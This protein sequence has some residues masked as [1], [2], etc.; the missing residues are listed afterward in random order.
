MKKRWKFLIGLLV[1]LFIA[2][3]AA[4][5]YFYNYAV[6]PEEKDF[7]GGGSNSEE[8]VQAEKWM[9]EDPQR[10]EWQIQ[11]EDGLTLSAIYLPA[12]QDQKKTAIIAHGYMGQAENMAQYADL[13]HQLG[14]NVLI[15]DARGHGKS[16]GDYVGFGWDERMDYLHWIDQVL[17]ETHSDERIVLHGESMGA[18]T[19]MMVSGEKMP[20][21]VR[22]IIED[23]G[24]TSAKDEL[25]FQLK[26][27]FGL[28][29][30]PL[31][32]VTSLVT[33]VRAGYFF[34]EADAVSQL[35]KNQTPMLFIHGDKDDFVPFYMLN[36]VYQATDAPKEKFVVKGAKHA[37]AL[38]KAPEEYKKR[39]Q[40]FLEKHP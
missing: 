22:A 40:A 5:N 18:A 15:P 38:S 4:G 32:P 29:S 6:V 17:A 30:F 13:Y 27:M 28:P 10:T 37:Q 9:A 8:R 19:V 23:C 2:L 35:K 12:E 24:Y 14:Y 16:E 21:N 33:K 31:I 36:E 3:I 39:V 26:Q 7:I 11:S 20:E 25:S 1:V 34:G